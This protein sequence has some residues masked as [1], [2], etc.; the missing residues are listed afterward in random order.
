MPFLFADAD[1]GEAA[2]GEAVFSTM[3]KIAIGAATGAITLYED[4]FLAETSVEHLASISFDEIEVKA[5]A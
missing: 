2:S 4:V 3:R 1:D 5:G